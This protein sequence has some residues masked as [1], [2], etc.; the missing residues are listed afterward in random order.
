MSTFVREAT[1]GGQLRVGMMLGGVV[2]VAIGS[3]VGGP[4]Y[5]AAAT[6]GAPLNVGGVL[7]GLFAR[8]GWCCG[9]GGGVM[10]QLGRMGSQDR[11]GLP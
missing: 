8:Q 10:C 5:N 2:G 3:C 6:C 4:V 7:L 9:L 1:G 11:Q